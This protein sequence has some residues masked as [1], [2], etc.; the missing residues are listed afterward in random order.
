MQLT[1]QLI[2]NMLLLDLPSSSEAIWYDTPSW[3]LFRL[4]DMGTSFGQQLFTFITFVQW[5]KLTWWGGPWIVINN[6]YIPLGGLEISMRSKMTRRQGDERER[7]CWTRAY[8]SNH[9][10][11]IRDNTPSAKEAWRKIGGTE[12]WSVG[13]TAK[14]RTEE[15]DRSMRCAASELKIILN[16]NRETA[17]SRGRSLSPCQWPQKEKKRKIEG[18][19]RRK[20]NWNGGGV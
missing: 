12:K 14:W 13:A 18:K 10:R 1:P 5:A 9:G 4:Q 2:G 3:G 20:G 16:R 11:E 15:R 8:V 17:H 6:Q 19:K 7:K